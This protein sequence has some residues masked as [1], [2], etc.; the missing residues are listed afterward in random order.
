MLIFSDAILRA[1]CTSLHA[2][3]ACA[4]PSAINV[5]Y[6]FDHYRIEQMFFD[7]ALIPSSGMLCPNSTSLGFG[8]ECKLRGME[9]YKVMATLLN[10]PLHESPHESQIDW[11]QYPERRRPTTCLTIWA[12]LD[13][14]SPFSRALQWVANE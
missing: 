14:I 6:L 8:L 11:A 7:G 4:L 1:H 9:R 5:E 3:A 2:Q 12:D 13:V 10:E